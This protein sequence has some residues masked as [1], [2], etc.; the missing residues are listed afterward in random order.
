MV[1]TCPRCGAQYLPRAGEP[2]CPKCKASGGEPEAWGSIDEDWGEVSDL[3]TPPPPPLQLARPPARVERAAGE[4]PEQ[5][6]RPEP[7]GGPGQGPVVASPEEAAGPG[8][9]DGRL[10]SEGTTGQARKRTRA[11]G[12]KR[13]RPPVQPAQPV[14]ARKRRAPPPSSVEKKAEPRRWP[15]WLL[16]VLVLL[17][18]ILVVALAMIA[19]RGQS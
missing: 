1:Q 4:E 16:P 10:A 14:K 19:S 15:A 8:E 3:P 7:P 2:G 13:S 17:A 12:K 11:R 6:A 5:E 18:A 9:Q